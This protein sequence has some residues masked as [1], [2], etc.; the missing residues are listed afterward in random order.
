MDIFISRTHVSGQLNGENWTVGRRSGL[1]GK[2]EKCH[3]IEVRS[4]FLVAGRNGPSFLMAYRE[5]PLFKTRLFCFFSHFSKDSL[6]YAPGEIF[7]KIDLGFG[8]IHTGPKVTQLSA[9]VVGAKPPCHLAD[10]AELVV[11]WRSPWRR[12]HWRQ[13]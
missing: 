2:K 4:T 11:T 6:K 12:R 10:D 8:T 13:A 7:Q 3:G 1:G 5:K 9:V